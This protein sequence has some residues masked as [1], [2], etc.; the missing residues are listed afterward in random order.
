MYHL[1][2][3]SVTI[4]NYERAQPQTLHQLQNERIRHSLLARKTY[5]R[6]VPDI[7]SDITIL[8]Q[9]YFQTSGKGG[10]IKQQKASARVDETSCC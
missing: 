1:D 7:F 4:F 5:D 9:T 10:V 2:F 3:N 8:K 6:I